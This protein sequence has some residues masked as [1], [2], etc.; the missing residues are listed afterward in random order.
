MDD[1]II[2]VGHYDLYFKVQ[3]FFL[4]ISNSVLWIYII[5]VLWILVHYDTM[6]EL[7]VLKGQYDL[8]FI[9]Q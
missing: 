3:C 5:H 9:V 7:I 2:L 1:L 8:Y 4:N 6:S